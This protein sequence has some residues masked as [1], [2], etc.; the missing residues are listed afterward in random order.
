MAT[1]TNP[2]W[3][4][5]FPDPFVL[6]FQ[7]RFYAYATETGKRGSG[8]QVMESPDLVHWTHRGLAFT[9]A[10]SQEHLW[11]PEVAAYRGSLYMI[12]SA[13]DKR[14]N[15]HHIGIA[16]ADRPTG[17]FMHRAM[18][19]E[20]SPSPISSIDATLFFD[21]DRTPYLIYSEEDPR[22]I[23]LR[24]L[25][26]DLLS[27]AGDPIELIR[28]T[29]PEERGV[30]EAPTL[31]KRGRDYVLF[32]S[33]GWFQS[34]KADASYAVY[35]AKS[36]NLRGPYTKSTAPLLATI[37]GKLYGPGHQCVV[38]TGKNDWWMLYHG[39]GDEN[40]PRY[41]SNPQGRTLRLDRLRWQGSTPLMAPATTGPTDAPKL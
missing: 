29:R 37:P 24:P 32:Y 13:L 15:R 33:S 34:S 10:W 30:T 18:L 39:W 40:E 22:R 28:P 21:D 1:Y 6:K 14:D 35:Y 8:F 19:I 7:G 5:D 25:A 27:V 4:E 16:T 9:P 38:Q 11:A 12:Y 23:V 41:G 17:P 26:P 31:I 20:N 2:V 3:G 36:P